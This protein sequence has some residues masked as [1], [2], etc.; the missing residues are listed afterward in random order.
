MRVAFK[1]SVVRALHEEREVD[2]EL[3]N[4]ECCR[5]LGCLQWCN[6]YVL[7]AT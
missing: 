2:I 3:L 5:N 7:R 4:A 1:C 6:S